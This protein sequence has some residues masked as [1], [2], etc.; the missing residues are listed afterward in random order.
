MLTG[1]SGDFQILQQAVANTNDWGLACEITCY[2]EL[3]DDVTVVTIKI[4]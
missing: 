2:R 1:P 4:K 3:D